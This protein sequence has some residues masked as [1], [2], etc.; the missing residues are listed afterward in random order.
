MPASA[1]SPA[2]VF[3]ASCALVIG[4]TLALPFVSGYGTSLFQAVVGGA[5]SIVAAVTSDG[6][7]DL[8][9]LVVWFFAAALNVVLFSIPAACVLFATRDRWPVAGTFL[10]ALWL[11]FYAASLFI[12]FPA[13][14]GP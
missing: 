11:M 9:K 10:L 2:K 4:S 14:D 5:W 7:A 3:W 1:L 12:L 13:T 6:F 8:H